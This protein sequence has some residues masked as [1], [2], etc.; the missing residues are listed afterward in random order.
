MGTERPDTAG[1]MGR[2]TSSWKTRD[3]WRSC[4][5]R[6]RPRYTRQ[7][8]PVGSAMSRATTGF[9]LN[10]SAP[11]KCGGSLGLNQANCAGGE[12]TEKDVKC[13]ECEVSAQVILE[14]GSPL[15]VGCPECGSSESY[16]DFQQSSLHQASVH[17]S[18]VIGK[19]LKDMA[20]KNK[21][22]RFEPGNIRPP[23][24]SLRLELTE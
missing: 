5:W 13:S 15:K 2:R 11:V 10:L 1:D 6:M 14:E 20:M 21:N 8:S 7:L 4:K 18:N 16:D 12:M 3:Q 17:A 19:S 24:P 22:F 23:N 9:F